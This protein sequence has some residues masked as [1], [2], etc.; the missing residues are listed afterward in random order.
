MA[1][2]VIPAGD[3]AERITWCRREHDVP[4]PR[5]VQAAPQPLQR[6]RV[7]SVVQVAIGDG[8]VEGARVAFELP[9][10]PERVAHARAWRKAYLAPEP[11]DDRPAV[12]HP[13]REIHA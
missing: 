7:L 2:R 8:D 3:L 9:G 12:F 1:R 10:P 11:V 4:T 6:V 5:R 13:G